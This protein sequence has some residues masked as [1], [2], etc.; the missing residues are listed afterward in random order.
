MLYSTYLFI[1]IYLWLLKKLLLCLKELL[2]GDKLREITLARGFSVPEQCKY[3][4]CKRLWDKT[5]MESEQQCSALD[6]WG[7]TVFCSSTKGFS[8]VSSSY[9]P[10]WPFGIVCIRRKGKKQQQSQLLRMKKNWRSAQQKSRQTPFATAP[11]SREIRPRA[12]A[13]KCEEQ[14]K[15]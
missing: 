1:P 12:A 10:L 7:S 9:A 14:S 3:T 6:F 2:I 15:L 13:G 8:L 5:T 11:H 4:C